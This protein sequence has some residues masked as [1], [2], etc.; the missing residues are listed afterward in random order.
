MILKMNN[1]EKKSFRLLQDRK[2]RNSIKNINPARKYPAGRVKTRSMIYTPPLPW[3]R[4][5]GSEGA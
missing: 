3:E 2:G 4:G 1:H 5:A